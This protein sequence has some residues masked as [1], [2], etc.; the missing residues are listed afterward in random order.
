MVSKESAPGI[1]MGLGEFVLR[2]PD[3]H[4]HI[5]VD[6][7]SLRAHFFIHNSGMRVARM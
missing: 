2:Q 3:I 4:I 1:V 7:V 6:L 5:H